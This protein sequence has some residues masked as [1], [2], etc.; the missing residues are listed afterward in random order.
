MQTAQITGT[1]NGNCGGC[2]PN[3]VTV[4]RLEMMHIFCYQ[5]GLDDRGNV[6]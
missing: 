1:L 6:I 5:N 3:G 2:H 4:P